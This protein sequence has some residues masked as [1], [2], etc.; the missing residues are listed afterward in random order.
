[1]RINLPNLL[2]LFRIAVIPG[3]VVL[4]Y[5][6]TRFSSWLACGLF[7]LAAITDFLDGYIA[8]ATQSQS[9]FGRFLDPVADKLLVASALLMMVAF[10]QISGLV[11]LP[12]LVI[13]CREITVSGLREYLA[14]LRV[15]VPVSQLAK[16]KTTLQMVSIA[17]L[18]VGDNGPPAIPLVEIGEA[19]LWIAAILTIVTGYDY[20]RAGL[21][22]IE[23]EDANQGAEQARLARG[24]GG[25]AE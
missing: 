12:A 23:R 18:I 15:G 14:G 17:V 16:W 25:G 7:S 4:F 9:A 2:T 11:I 13:L 22:H 8:R 3:L 10:G 6:E 1:M 24:G 20:Q 5:F 21:R 19:G